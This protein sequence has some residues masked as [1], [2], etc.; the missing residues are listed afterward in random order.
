VLRPALKHF[1]WTIGEPQTP[2]LLH[3]AEREKE[4]ENEKERERKKRKKERACE[5]ETIFERFCEQCYERDRTSLTLCTCETLFAFS[6][7][8][9]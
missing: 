4:S 6:P 8:I 1:D 5:K 3:L 7:I 2:S 9:T